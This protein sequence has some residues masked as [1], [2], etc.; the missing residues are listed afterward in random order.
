MLVLANLGGL[1]AL[2]FRHAPADRAIQVPRLVV[3]SILAG[4]VWGQ[5]M[6]PNIPQLFEYLKTDRALGVLN[7][8]W[9]WNVASHFLTGLP[10]NNFD[11]ASRGY[12]EL[13]W[14]IG[15]DRIV[16]ALLWG[17]AG[18]LFL[19]GA[20]VFLARRPAGWLVVAVLLIPAQLVYLSARIKGNYLYEWYVIFA[21]PGLCA[22]AAL[23]ADTLVAPLRR[24]RAGRYVAAVLLAAGV[25]GYAVFSQPARLWLLTHPLQPIRDAVLL[26]RPSL[27]PN[28]PRQQDIL[29]ASLNVHLESYDAHVVAV[30]DAQH[31]ADL[32]HQADAENKPLFVVTGNDFAFAQENP[33]LRN[34]LTDPRYFERFARLP[35]FDH[36]LT[37]TIWLYR[38]GSLVGVP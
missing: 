31:L 29:T 7:A 2:W 30:K 1:V 36:T 13:Q 9:H 20:A 34:L 18:L 3:V 35:G 38:P 10:W 22:C 32:A 33:D 37:Q 6:A 8:R 11:E 19:I 12:P 14:I 27:D 5:L 26:I 23:A 16:N 24:G 28:D 17:A 25:A 4:M 15:N 21:L